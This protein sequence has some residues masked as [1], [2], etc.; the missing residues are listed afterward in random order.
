MKKLRLQLGAIGALMHVAQ[1]GDFIYCKSSTG[2][3]SIVTDNGETT[4]LEP[5]ATARMGDS[6]RTFSIASDSL[7][8]VVTIIVGKGWYLGLREAP[9]GSAGLPSL[10]GYQDDGGSTQPLRGASRGLASGTPNMASAPGSEYW[11]QQVPSSGAT[12][13]MNFEGRDLSVLVIQV[14]DYDPANP[15]TGYLDI[16]TSKRPVRQY[17][18]AMIWDESFTALPVQGRI[19]ANGFYYMRASGIGAIQVTR[20]GVQTNTAFLGIV[21]SYVPLLKP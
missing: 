1:G 17:R 10:A 20:S 18:A 8:D 6:F 19:T 3:L 16:T 14:D 13:T 2:T 5:G 15:W 12:I 21:G 7:D 4:L 9:G 11:S